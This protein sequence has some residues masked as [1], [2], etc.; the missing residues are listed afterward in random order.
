M[1]PPPLRRPASPVP[2]PPAPERARVLEQVE[3]QVWGSLHRQATPAEARAHGW[4]V[5]DTAAATLLAAARTDVLFF[6]RVM[7][8]G[9]DA[10]ATEDQLHAIVGRY[11][12][13]GVPRFF[14]QVSPAAVPAALFGWLEARGFRHHNSWAKLF[15]GVEAPPEVATDL[16]IEE[17]GPA[18]AGVIS[19][20]AAT[21]FDWPP[22]SQ[23]LLARLMQQSGW[24]RYLAF[25]GEA[26]VAA[27]GLY[28]TGAHGYL[29][30]AV[31]LPSHRGRGAQSA[32]IARRIH[33]AAADGCTLLV[34]ETAED[35]PEHPAPSFRNMQRL[36]FQLAYLRPN[37]LL[38]LHP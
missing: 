18:W 17:V 24:R 11:R 38:T 10:P 8:W 22:L 3:R 27:A 2:H 20:M 31:T 35:R 28:V 14:I 23:A 19:A 15:R 34:T 7:G 13:A 1:L 29:G 6:N 16:R 9:L 30:P 12:A 4:M 33:D 21:A 25:D 36:G 5:A 37:Y 32:L 26:P